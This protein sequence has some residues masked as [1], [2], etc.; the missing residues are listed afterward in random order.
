ME[1]R[2]IQRLVRIM[3]RADLSDLELEDTKA[4]FRVRLRRGGKVPAGG[5]PVVHVTQGAAP[6]AAPG[7]AGEAAPAAAAAPTAE[8][9]GRPFPS[10]MVG[11]FYRSPAPDADPFVDVGDAIGPETVVCIIEAMKVM[12]EIKAETSGTVVEVLVENGE[13]VEFGQP[14]FLLK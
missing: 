2:L 1:T 5:A 3:Q 14:L 7:A 9:A 11:T 6:T 12:N 13:P 10:P 4:G 8:P